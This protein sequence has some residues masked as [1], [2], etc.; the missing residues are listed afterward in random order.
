MISRFFRLSFALVMLLVLAACADTILPTLETAI[1]VDAS[2]VSLAGDVG[3]TLS[4]SFS[5]ENTAGRPERYRAS[6][7]APWLSI[8]SGAS[9]NVK[10]GRTATVGLRATCS[11]EG[12]FQTN[13]SIS[14][15]RTASEM[16]SVSLTCN[17]DTEPPPPPPPPPPSGSEF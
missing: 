11:E 9:G 2:S 5:V 7:N 13:V 4:G 8:V 12:E 1:R 16:V 6:E 15:N 14:S 17:E 3:D 10:R